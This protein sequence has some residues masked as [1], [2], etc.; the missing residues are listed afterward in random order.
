MGNV[1]LDQGQDAREES[2]LRHLVV[3]LQAHLKYTTTT[4]SKSTFRIFHDFV[5][6]KCIGILAY[7]TIEEQSWIVFR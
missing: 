1:F 2:S 3:D 7:S 5:Q 6:D 4:R